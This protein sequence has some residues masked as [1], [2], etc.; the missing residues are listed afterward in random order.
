MFIYVFSRFHF[1]ILWFQPIPSPSPS[2]AWSGYQRCGRRS[3]ATNV[4]VSS[5]GF[6]LVISMSTHGVRWFTSFQSVIFWCKLEDQ[7]WES[8]VLDV[9]LQKHING[10]PASSDPVVSLKSCGK[11]TCGKSHEISRLQQLSWASRMGKRTKNRSTKTWKHGAILVCLNMD[12]KM[13]RPARNLGVIATRW[14][15]TADE[16]LWLSSLSN[17]FNLSNLSNLFYPIL[18]YPIYRSIHLSM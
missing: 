11:S 14:F 16:I 17:Q 1:K 12:T 18:S 4:Q 8:Y 9:D 5:T 2:P 6:G 3:G 7:R 13:K 15:P 10:R